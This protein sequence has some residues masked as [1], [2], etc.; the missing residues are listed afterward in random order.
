MKVTARDLRLQTRRLLEAV[1]RG[2]EVV[3]TYHGKPRA[4]LVPYDGGG[5]QPQ[6]GEDVLFGMWSDDERSEDIEAY[7]NEMRRPRI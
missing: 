4:R 2:E 1:G 3:I 7:I 5:D 6:Y